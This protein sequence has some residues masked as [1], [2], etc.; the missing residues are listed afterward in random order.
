MDRMITSQDLIAFE[1]HLQQNE[2][3][4]FTT[5]KYMRDIRC[6]FHYLQGQAVT[7]DAVIAYKQSLSNQ[8]YAATSVNSMLGALNCFLEFKGWSDCKVK[9]IRLQKKIYCADSMELTKQEYLRLLE[10]AKNQP[11]TQLVLQTLCATGIRVSELRFFTVENIRNGE[12]P[13]TCKSKVR[14]VFLPVKL[15][16]K[17]LSWAE[18]QNIKKGN[19]FVTNRGKPLDRSYI[20]AQMKALCLR[21]NVDPHK[22]FPHNLRKLFARTFYGFDKDIAKLADILG[23]E[24]IETTRIYIMSTGKEHRQKLE[25]LDLVI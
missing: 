15:Q 21:A 16:E 18:S 5:T 13:V 19:V 11:R 10:A 14:T 23:H 9:Y 1:N 3:S 17:L 8:G 4:P 20:W 2:K 7:K 6:F 25:Q 22:V 12:I 24:S